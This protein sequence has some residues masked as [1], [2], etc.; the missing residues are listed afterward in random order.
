MRTSLDPKWIIFTWLGVGCYT[1]TIKSCIELWPYWLLDCTI[2]FINDINDPSSRYGLNLI[3]NIRNGPL[4]GTQTQAWQFYCILV[5]IS[6]WLLIRETSNEIFI[7][8]FFFFQEFMLFSLL[9]FFP[10]FYFI[11]KPSSFFSLPRYM[12]LGPVKI[13]PSPCPFWGPY[14]KEKK[15]KTKAQE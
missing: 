10:C 11:T 6:L 12:H 3:V 4:G 7:Q 1:L 15:K 13:S 2:C 9:Y 5:W 14:E 8:F